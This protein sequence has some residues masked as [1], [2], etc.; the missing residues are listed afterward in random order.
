MQLKRKSKT[1]RKNSVKVKGQTTQLV[2]RTQ[3]VYNGFTNTPN[4]SIKSVRK[5]YGFEN[6]SLKSS[7]EIASL[8]RKNASPI[9]IFTDDLI[10][11]FK[12]AEI[13]LNFADILVDFVNSMKEKLPR[14]KLNQA[15][16]QEY[17]ARVILHL[18]DFVKFLNKHTKY[19]KGDIATVNSLIKSQ[20]TKHNLNLNAI[21]G[22]ASFSNR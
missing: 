13:N 20:T 10:V 12:N 21:K 3:T 6:K 7:A 16:L 4:S 14:K 2:N 15:D 17:R 11:V 22:K 8:I 18:T 19:S 9:M 5:K 1:K